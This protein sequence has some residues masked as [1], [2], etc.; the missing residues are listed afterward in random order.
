MR[1]KWLIVAEILGREWRRDGIPPVYNRDLD[2]Y[3]PLMRAHDL[4]LHKHVKRPYKRYADSKYY[5]GKNTD[6]SFLIF[7][8]C[9]RNPIC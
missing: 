6:I 2:D 8:K 3:L 5:K 1:C 7:K 9:L 4:V